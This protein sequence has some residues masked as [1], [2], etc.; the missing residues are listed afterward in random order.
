MR[1]DQVYLIVNEFELS[2]PLLICLEI[3]E[4]P[5]MPVA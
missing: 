4:I 3:P 5:N 2:Y 1:P